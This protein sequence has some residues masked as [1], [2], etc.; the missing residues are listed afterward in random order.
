MS[1]KLSSPST[2]SF[3][4]W[5]GIVLG[6]LAIVLALVTMAYTK[7]IREGLSQD[8]HTYWLRALVVLFLSGIV[9]AIWRTRALGSA[10]QDLKNEKKSSHDLEIQVQELENELR[11]A[12]KA[13]DEAVS[14]R[15]L[16]EKDYIPYRRDTKGRWNQITEI[17]YGHLEYEPFLYYQS[18]TPTGL[19]VDLLAR[20]LNPPSDQTKIKIDA[21]DNER[22]W[23]NILTGL[24]EK[25]YDVI[26]TPLFATFDRSKLVRFTTPLFFSNIGLFVNKE[27]ASL[28][29][30]KDVT[31]ETMRQDIETHARLT[32]LAVKEEISQQLARKCVDDKLIHYYEGKVVPGNLFDAIAKPNSQN[33]L[34]CESFYAHHQPRVRSGEVV[35]VLPSHQILYPVCFAV[36]QGDYQ[37][38]NLLNIRLLRMT[39]SE[40]ALDL[41][42]KKLGSNPIYS[43]YL[44]ELK[45][46]FVDDWPCPVKMKE[47]THA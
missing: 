25:Q 23:N 2:W 34:F 16:M 18:Q 20:L 29:F 28:S 21:Y 41:L 11:A 14:Q 39:Q 30:W 3:E 6:V 42:A 5:C 7:E 32:F 9:L 27:I 24:V 44:D 43:P 37:L 4:T 40:G 47:S 12:N 46:H 13:R 26:A 22:N 45:L 8:V 35:N 15:D 10:K 33:A 38:A 1:A 17:T 19:G 36:R 31:P